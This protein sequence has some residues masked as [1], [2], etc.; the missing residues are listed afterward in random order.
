MELITTEENGKLV[1][2]TRAEYVANRRATGALLILLIVA[3]ML[4]VVCARA[5]S[6][7][8]FNRFGLALYVHNLNPFN[9]GPDMVLTLKQA[10]YVMP[11]RGSIDDAERGANAMG[12][13][14]AGQAVRAH[15]AY[16]SAGSTW[17]AVTAYRGDSEVNGWIWLPCEQLTSNDCVEERST[18]A[19]W[20]VKSR[21][22]GYALPLA[23]KRLEEL[24]VPYRRVRVTRQIETDIDRL[25]DGNG[26]WVEVGDWFEF[27]VALVVPESR[28]DDAKSAIAWALAR[29]K[30]AHLRSVGA[31]AS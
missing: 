21:F 7:E 3:V 30:A 1:T 20:G 13:L 18:D 19:Y 31:V 8:T 23:I 14:Q 11:S 24:G 10:V 12:V 4:Y 27:H 5:T 16:A 26:N 28:E 29:A 17:W 25:S 2:R 22:Q 15:G 6:F 9:D